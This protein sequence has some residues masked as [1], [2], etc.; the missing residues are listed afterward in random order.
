MILRQYSGIGTVY[1]DFDT[2]H[3]ILN[4]RALLGDVNAIEKLSD[5]L[6]LHLNTLLNEG[7]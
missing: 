1:S 5:V 3:S 7:G 2:Q 6:V 4:N